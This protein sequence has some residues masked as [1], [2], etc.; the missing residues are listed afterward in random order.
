MWRP[1]HCKFLLCSSFQKSTTMCCQLEV[2]ILSSPSPQRLQEKWYCCLEADLQW[3]TLRW[4]PT[5]CLEFHFLQIPARISKPFSLCFVQ[6]AED[7]TYKFRVVEFSLTLDSSQW[8]V[9]SLLQPTQT[10]AFGVRGTCL[11]LPAA[12]LANKY[13]FWRKKGKSNSLLVVLISFV[14]NMFS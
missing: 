1:L 9:I 7:I 14:C 13:L 8:T 2:S 5:A 11:I 3:E 4:S 6:M 12:F 10:Q